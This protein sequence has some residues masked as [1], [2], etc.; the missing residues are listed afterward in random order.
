MYAIKNKPEDFV[1]E[2]ILSERI[3]LD[4]VSQSKEDSSQD[5]K[6]KLYILRKKS[7]ETFALLRYLSKNNNIPL[8][9][10]GFAGLKDKHASTMQ[11]ITIPSQYVLKTIKEKNFE[12]EFVGY[13]E[14]PIRTGD[15][16]G[17]KFTVVARG[18]S[19]KEI[20]KVKQTLSRRK[21]NIES[22]G[23]PNYFDSQRFGSVIHREFIAKYLMRKDYENAVKIFITKYTPSERAKSKNEKR[24]IEKEWDKILEGE[25]IETKSNLFKLILNEYHASKDWLG[26]YKKIPRNLR[27]M[28]VI[29]YQSYIWN[30]CIKEAI[31][32]VVKEDNETSNSLTSFGVQYNVGKM[33]FFECIE[34]A[35]K[36][37]LPRRFKTLSPKTGMSEYEEKIIKNVIQREGV[38]LSDFDIKKETGT[39]FSTLEREAFVKPKDLT[40]SSPQTDEINSK[41]LSQGNGNR[42][43]NYRSA[44]GRM[45]KITLSFSLPKGSYATVVLKYLFG[46]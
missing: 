46:V 30:E 38:K 25:K 37:A 14:S 24:K 21:R 28:F 10:I 42:N 41:D 23:I 36:L 17:N 33:L 4:K 7:L 5:K 18:F 43:R 29:A 9:D 3:N 40:I 6:Y 31:R 34:G 44:K 27:E 12:I 15:L 32:E 19:E 22:Y 39:F 11:H 45:Y 35:E 8:K 16:M 26:A 13:V 20:E 1:V 2:E